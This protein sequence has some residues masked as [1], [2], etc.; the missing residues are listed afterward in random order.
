MM[1]QKL[2][3]QG[4]GI[5]DIGFETFVCKKTQRAVKARIEIVEKVFQGGGDEVRIKSD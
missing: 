4:L 1:L 2:L 3:R 5:L